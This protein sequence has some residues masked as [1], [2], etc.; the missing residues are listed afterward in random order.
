M[1]RF[2]LLLALGFFACG[3][4]SATSIVP[5]SLPELVAE[6][7]HVLVGTVT[8]VSMHGA[9]GGEITDPKAKTGPGLPNELRLHVTLDPKGVIK[10][11]K[12]PLPSEIVVPLWKMWHS[13]FESVRAGREGQ[14]RI[15]LLKG[16]P[17]ELVYPGGC[18]LGVE[19]RAE[20]ETLLAA[21]ATKPTAPAAT[22]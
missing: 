18:E 14:T 12:S 17:M 16:D 10:T 7:D 2:L 9:D 1:T 6:A 8:R 4:L 22:R 20:I 19:K 15:F 5:K 13:T 3:S 11:D 21:P